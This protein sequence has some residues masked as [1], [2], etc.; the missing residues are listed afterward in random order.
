MRKFKRCEYLS[1]DVEIITIGVEQGF[2]LSSEV[3]EWI[4]G[5]EH[6]GSVE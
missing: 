5:G 3:N 1:P 4:D 6:G 2:L